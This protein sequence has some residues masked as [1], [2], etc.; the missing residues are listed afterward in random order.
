MFL[1]LKTKKWGEEEQSKS[2]LWTYS[3]MGLRTLWNNGGLGPS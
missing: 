2:S 1:E 3:V